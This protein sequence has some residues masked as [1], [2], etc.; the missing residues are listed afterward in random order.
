[1]IQGDQ[2]IKH[3][4]YPS[5]GARRFTKSSASAGVGVGIGVAVV[6]TL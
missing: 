6:S 1:L 2:K 3:S 5:S 4:N